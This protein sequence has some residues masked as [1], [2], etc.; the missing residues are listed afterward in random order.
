LLDD[1]DALGSVVRQSSTVGQ[2]RL[3]VL[4]ACASTHTS[5]VTFS[6]KDSTDNWREI[7]ACVISSYKKTAAVWTGVLT[8]STRWR[9]FVASLLTDEL[10]SYKISAR[11]YTIVCARQENRPI[12]TVISFLVQK[13]CTVTKIR[14]LTP[15]IK[16]PHKLNTQIWF[17]SMSNYFIQAVE[18]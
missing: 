12:T 3:Q 1:L 16:L 6:H 15:T 9:H 18:Y 7:C 10:T 8:A 13:N 2:Q 5:L 4:C 17:L 11:N 14:L